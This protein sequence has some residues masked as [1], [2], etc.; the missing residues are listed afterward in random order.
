MTSAEILKSYDIRPSVIRV[1]I[2]DYLKGTDVHPTVDEIY[3]E[4]SE[5]IP[6][7]SKTSVYN[8]VKLFADS[9]LSKTITI[10]KT[11]VR[12]DADITMHGHF[13]CEKCNKVYDFSLDR[14]LTDDLVGFDIS[15]KEVYYC[16]VCRKCNKK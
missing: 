13:M 6:T 16:G 14:N 4:L 7:L 1:M 3:T 9:G 15:A 10:D 5:K 2:Y 12:Y 11:Q 8:T